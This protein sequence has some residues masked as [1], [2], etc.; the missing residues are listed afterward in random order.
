MKE[1]KSE[2]ALKKN[3]F[4]EKTSLEKFEEKIKQSIFIVLFVLLKHEEFDFPM[5]MVTLLS[6]LFQFMF[7]PFNQNVI[8]FKYNL[9]STL[10]FGKILIFMKV[11]KAFWDILHF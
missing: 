8:L 7:Y 2:V 5:E 6:E 11:Y 1:K 4:K 3:F 9:Y 10:I